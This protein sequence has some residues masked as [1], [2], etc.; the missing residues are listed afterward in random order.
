V[1]PRLKTSN[2]LC[3]GPEL[4]LAIATAYRADV[5]FKLEGGPGIGKTESVAAAADALDVGLINLNL[6]VMEPTDLVGL[7]RSDGELLRYHRPEWLERVATDERGGFL[8]LD[9]INRVPRYMVAPL[10]AILTGREVNGVRFQSNW[11]PCAAANVGPDFDTVGLDPALESRFLTI[12]VEASVV[13]WSLW[14]KTVR[15]DDRV[16]SFVE[17][18]HGIFDSSSPREWAMVGRLLEESCDSSVELLEVLVAGVVGDSLASAF[19]AYV[20]GGLEPL[21]P[22]DVVAGELA[23]I[24]RLRYWVAHGNVALIAGSAKRVQ[25]HVQPSVVHDVLTDDERRNI[26]R[27]AF[28]LPDDLRDQWNAWAIR[29][30]YQ[31]FVVRPRRAG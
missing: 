9:E 5:P 29:C 6:A 3:A 16:I 26:V 20:G 22:T 2:R 11:L 13:Q 12:C 4:T 17:A 10:H 21:R 8:F 14:A 31:D 24:E 15:L 25:V 19:V 27:F 18:T 28:H 7:P 30:G 1:S 23:V